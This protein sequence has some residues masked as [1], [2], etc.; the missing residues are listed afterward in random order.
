MQQK[1]KIS[2]N[3]FPASK[4]TLQRALGM[5]W[6]IQIFKK[7]S[8]NGTKQTKIRAKF[9]FCQKNRSQ[10]GSNS[11][12]S[13]F[14]HYKHWATG[15]KPTN[16]NRQTIVRNSTKTVV[17]KNGPSR[18]WAVNLCRTK[19]LFLPLREMRWMIDWIWVYNYQAVTKPRKP[20]QKPFL[21]KRNS[22]NSQLLK[23]FSLA[24]TRARKLFF[25]R[26]DAIRSHWVDI[27]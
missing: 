10:I 7:K 9:S 26:N 24:Y 8:L 27:N 23:N 18:I 19:Q 6:G 22:K 12:T 17:C 4:K 20:A 3:F 21:P 25:G 1:F 14:K 5:L 13:S 16:M 2:E 15:T 11:R